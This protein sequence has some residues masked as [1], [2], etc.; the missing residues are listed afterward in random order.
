[1]PGD[2]FLF[3]GNFHA[4]FEKTCG[5]PCR[6]I[7]VNDRFRNLTG[8]KSEEN[9]TLQL[10]ICKDDVVA[11]RKEIEHAVKNGR[12]YEIAYKLEVN[13]ELIPVTEIGYVSDDGP[14][15]EMILKGI[16][17]DRKE[18]KATEATSYTYQAGINLLSEILTDLMTV[19]KYSIDKVIDSTLMKAGTIA[20]VDRCNLFRIDLDETTTW[21]THE[22]LKSSNINTILQLGVKISIND[23]PWSTSQLMKNESVVIN[24][25]DDLE[26]HSKKDK[27]SFSRFN[28]LSRVLV[29]VR[30]KNKLHGFIGFETNLE[31]RE[32]KT[33]EIKLFELC[34]QIVAQSLDQIDSKQ[35]YHNVLNLLYNTI[36]SISEGILIQ[37][38]KGDFTI[39]NNAFADIADIKQFD[40]SQTQAEINLTINNR[41]KE[42]GV[43]SNL[44]NSALQS[45][46]LPEIVDC[47]NG[48]I[49]EVQR[50]KRTDND[51]KGGWFWRFKDITEVSTTQALLRENEERYEI[52]FS[53]GN[54]AVL[55]MDN[56]IIID[57]NQKSCELFEC[58][59]EML[60][61]SN[62]NKYL[63]E[64]QPDGMPSTQNA[65]I[66]KV[67]QGQPQVV[68]YKLKTAK[69]NLLDAEINLQYFDFRGKR[70]IQAIHRDITNLKR[71]ELLRTVMYDIA[72]LSNSVNS[73]DEL[74]KGIHGAISRMLDA[75]NFYIAM[76]EPQRQMIHFPY[77]VDTVDDLPEGVRYFPIGKGLTE[78]VMF[79]GETVFLTGEQLNQLVATSDEYEFVGEPSE[80]WLGVPLK[81]DEEIFG[82]M[83]VQH[84][85]DSSAYDETDK[86][87]MIYV[88]NQVAK[89]I[90]KVRTEEEIKKGRKNLA[91]AQHISKLGS[92]E[93][94]MDTDVVFWS[95]E[96]YRILGHEPWTVQPGL[97]SFLKSLD[98]T[99]SKVFTETMRKASEENKPQKCEIEAKLAD[100]QVKYMAASFEVLIADV[101]DK[102]MIGSVQD[103]TDRK[104][105]E[106]ELQQVTNELLSSN[107]ELEQFAYI[108]SH[109]LRSPVANIIGLVDV[110]KMNEFEDDDIRMVIDK[111][112]VSISRMEQ[113]IRD[114]SNVLNIKKDSVAPREH[115]EFRQLLE[116][117]MLS[118][119]KLVTESK[120]V[121]QA[122]FKKVPAIE[123]LNTHLESIML[124]MLTNAIKYRSDKRALKIKISTKRLG[125]FVCLKIVDNG[126]GI[127]LER[128]GD[129]IFGLYQRFH[130]HVEGKGLGLYIINNQVMALGGRIEVDSL[131]GKGTTFSIFL[132][133][134]DAS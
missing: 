27:E 44:M 34:G 122:D 24:Q 7:Y 76:F 61:G 12:S 85:E 57:C 110:L 121:I 13:G 125:E 75:S 36:E 104:L 22:W 117:T 1:M 73:L 50:A 6:F 99:N 82:V 23:F 56:E 45:G 102:L 66:D 11:Y 17:V 4:Y 69:N 91:L 65:I 134:P 68:E 47:H 133:C 64:L 2:D 10:P 32:W 52:L 51:K 87:L 71:N 108:T 63:G 55:I 46:E 88:S 16:L 119:E 123:Y 3:A 33:D 15:N 89:V 20:N 109:N 128:Y 112:D 129:R 60:I 43:I 101:R 72:Q 132:H 62:I 14:G 38:H 37:N 78:K 21:K 35:R 116:N 118:I 115:I 105:S 96:M 41:L 18:E 130:D 70:Y 31:L 79:S 98:K 113:T 42:N 84:Y 92:W 77:Y 59:R 126:R 54:D 8:L 26:T 81:V 67:L 97:K 93:W 25:L 39:Y 131:P 107:K 49:Y 94:N 28:V 83:V 19:D 30:V 106:M 111:I 53:R 95:A 103:I 29:P 9:Q 100:G 40:V 124:N 90:H 74:F 48:Q 86:D 120:A 127:D 5:N 58:S 114:L 80:I